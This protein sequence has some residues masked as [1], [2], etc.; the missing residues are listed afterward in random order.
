MGIWVVLVLP[1]S[2]YG[3]WVALRFADWQIHEATSCFKQ[4]LQKVSKISSLNRL[5][6]TR[7]FAGAIVDVNTTP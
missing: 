4:P 5:A 2:F 1:I 7:C 3:R 6:T